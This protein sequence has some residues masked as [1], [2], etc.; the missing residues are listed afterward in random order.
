M[1]ESR[2]DARQRASRLSLIEKT[3]ALIYY[4]IYQAIARQWILHHLH[5]RARY[6]HYLL[7]N[8]LSLA[9]GAFFFVVID[10]IL[11]TAIVARCQT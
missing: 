6:I 2:A 5:S 9:P 10:E 4:Q 3:G 7:M 1:N 11:T 8:N